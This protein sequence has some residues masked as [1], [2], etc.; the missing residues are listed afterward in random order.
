MVRVMVRLMLRKLFG[1]LGVVMV[2]SEVGLEDRCV[3]ICCE[4]GS[5]II[6]FVRPSDL[7]EYDVASKPGLSEA[8]A[9]KLPVV[10]LYTWTKS[11]TRPPPSFVPYWTRLGHHQRRREWDFRLRSPMSR[12]ESSQDLK[13]AESLHPC[14]WLCCELASHGSTWPASDVDLKE[15]AEIEHEEQERS[16]S[17]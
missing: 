12:C 5:C 10:L 4:G 15:F 7:N 16:W 11:Y 9:S 2:E 1:E 13:G 8:P 17:Y 14:R 6:N 3:V